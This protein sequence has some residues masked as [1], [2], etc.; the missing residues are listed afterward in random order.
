MVNLITDKEVCEYLKISRPTLANY[1]KLGMPYKTIGTRTL[2]YVL[3]DVQ[4]WVE[5]GGASKRK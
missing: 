2:R 1:R 3:E 5:K 4:T